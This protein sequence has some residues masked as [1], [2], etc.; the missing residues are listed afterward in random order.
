MKVSDICKSYFSGFQEVSKFKDNDN[1]TNAIALLKILS[2]F[3]GVIPLG[4]A[5][6]YGAASL[7]GRISKKQHLSSH[8]KS[9]SDQ[10]KKTI[11]KS[12]STSHLKSD[13]KIDS[14]NTQNYKRE[15]EIFQVK[16]QKINELDEIPPA[17][18]GIVEIKMNEK[19]LELLIE[20][21]SQENPEV[22][23]L[24][25]ERSGKLY[26]IGGKTDEPVVTKTGV[27]ILAKPNLA[28]IFIDL[29]PLEKMTKID[30]FERSPQAFSDNVIVREASDELLITILNFKECKVRMFGTFRH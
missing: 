27:V 29:S 17:H 3:T 13:K 22:Q 19:T 4:F 11:L 28:K 24:Q 12:T 20:Y 1:K 23:L 25:D 8:D 30:I 16:I 26:L 7:C 2:Y 9:V 14:G 18:F 15:P 10:A 6:V 5:A 21:H